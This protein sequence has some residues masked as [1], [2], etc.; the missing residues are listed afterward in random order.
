MEYIKLGN[1]DL[2]VSRLC[3]GCM[4]FGEADQGQYQWTLDYESSKKI[5][6]K[7]YDCGINFFDTSNNYSNG[8]SEIFLGKT[9][10]DYR[11]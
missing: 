7:A 10:K 11:R 9:I 5:I 4:S 6:D 2:K 8:T 1:S 3:L